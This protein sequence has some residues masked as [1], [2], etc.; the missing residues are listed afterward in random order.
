MRGRLALGLGLVVM[1][2]IGGWISRA[3]LKACGPWGLSASFEDV[4]VPDTTWAE[5]LK[6]ELGILRAGLP[7]R[8]RV[9]AYR[10]LMGLPVTPEAWEPARG[11]SQNDPG[12]LTDWIEARKQVAVPEGQGIEASRMTATYVDYPHIGNH[13]FATA[14]ATLKARIQR[15]G[16]TSPTV[17][18]WVRGQDQVFLSRPENP[19]VPEP[20]AEPAW[21]RQDRDY[22]RASALF[23]ANRWDEARTLFAA[24]ARD[25]ASPWQPWGAYLQARCW[26]R[27][28]NLG[29]GAQAPACLAQA[30]SHL[31]GLLKDSALKTV[32]APARAYLELVRYRR[33]PQLLEV[34]ALETLAQPELGAGEGDAALEKLMQSRQWMTE[35]KKSAHTNLSPAAADLRA[36]LEAMEGSKNTDD[37]GTRTNSLPWRVAAL[38]TLDSQDPRLDEFLASEPAMPNG[39]A[40]PSL[41]W[42]RLRHTL[43]RSAPD[44]R[45]ALV[46]EALKEAWPR[47]AENQL[48]AFGRQN[49]PDLPRWASLLGS[50]VVALEVE[51]DLSAPNPQLPEEDAK[52]YG[53][54]PLLFEEITTAQLN[55]HLPLARMVELCERPELPLRLREDLA[56]AAWVRA[57]LLGRWEREQRLRKSLEPD[58]AKA[59]DPD[60]GSLDPTVRAFR[61]TL[62]FMKHPGLSPRIPGGMGRAIDG[63]ADW[64][65]SVDFGT[66]WWCSE[67]P[68]PVSVPAPAFLS[69]QELE[70]AQK[71]W[72]EIGKVPSARH[73]FGAAVLAQAEAHPDDPDLPYA[74]H[75]F[76]RITRN[77]DCYDAKLSALGK[78][79]FR[80]LHARY[81]KSPWARKTPVHY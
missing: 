24:I 35:T 14:A 6:G 70:T 7:L 69:H 40:D 62:V 22:Q 55:A 37:H 76:V 32:H 8:H 41:R 43:Q 11:E 39:A 65:V 31:E 19:S 4:R 25:Q 58:F 50:R 23:Y 54:N 34:E 75:R 78:R 59:L 66:N 51:T 49:A 45:V 63:W 48:R 10:H 28:S 42:H 47:W 26:F 13:A 80:L 44:A 12:D 1:A 77:A 38:A 73:W 71:E 18:D 27:Q 9:V 17:Q 68:Q 67:R 61:L 79:C 81:P 16:A 20:V 56:H 21:L 3:P 5:A 30:Q 52:H 2:G 64:T 29:E 36:W 74:L 53:K 60:F 72:A 15:H 33:E 46:R 57:A